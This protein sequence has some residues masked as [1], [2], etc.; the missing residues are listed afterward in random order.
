MHPSE[1]ARIFSEKSKEFPF[2]DCWFIE[3]FMILVI[4]KTICNAHIVNAEK[5]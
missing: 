3:W 4:I 5:H 1:A 2:N